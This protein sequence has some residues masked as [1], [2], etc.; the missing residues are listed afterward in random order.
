VL[1]LLLIFLRI[2]NTRV[3]LQ[4]SLDRAGEDIALSLSHVDIDNLAL[5][6]AL[7]DRIRQLVLLATELLSPISLLLISI[8][9]IHRYSPSVTGVCTLIQGPLPD[10]SSPLSDSSPSF[11]L[12]LSSL[13]SQCFSTN[14]TSLSLSKSIHSFLTISLSRPLFS[15]SFFLSLS[16]LI[17]IM[18]CIIWST[19]VCGGV[20]FWSFSRTQF[21]LSRI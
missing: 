2:L 17:I 6:N 13:L 21:R 11:S 7:G 5:Q 4:C 8:I 15:S 18:Y 20:I 10:T 1:V 9:L 14:S 16:W 19:F 3:L 12:S